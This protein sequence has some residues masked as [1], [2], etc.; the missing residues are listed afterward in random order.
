MRGALWMIVFLVVVFGG[1][2]TVALVQNSPPWREPPGLQERLKTYL[3]TNV[4]ETDERSPF[5]ELRSRHYERTAPDHLFGVIE[6]AISK[7]S[8]WQIV[9]RDPG[10]KIIRAVVT[11]QLWRFK[12][13]VTI[14]VVPEPA[15]D[16]A[17]LVVRSQ[18]RLG[19]G[20][21]AGNTRHILGLYAQLDSVIPPPRTA[22]YKTPP[23]R[24]T[25][26]F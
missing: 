8:S 11:S 17:R 22:A 16:G 19:K 12:D 26:L 4:A 7:M 13:D 3:G 21:L 18:S 25:P 20:D 5:P 1:S 24:T 15:S 2:L 23:A 10:R 9:E 6:Q 14:N